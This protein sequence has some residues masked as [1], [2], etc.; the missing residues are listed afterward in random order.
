M[1]LLTKIYYTL[2]SVANHPLKRDHK[3]RAI[4]E[5]C[6][7]QVAAR[8]FTGDVLVPFPNQT[9]L[10]VSPRM[11]G[12]AHFISPGLCEFDDMSFVTHFLRPNDLFADV[13]ANIGAYTV[14]ASGVAGARTVAFEPN[15]STFRYLELNALLNDLSEKVQLLNAAVG[16]KPGRLHMT[17]NLGT[18]NHICQDTTAA[19]ASG[20]IEVEVNTLD[21]VFAAQPPALL[22]MDVEGFETEALGGAGQL[23]SHPGLL[24][25][26]V[27]RGGMAT[28]YG[29]DERALHEQIRKQGFS[30]CAYSALERRLFSVAPETIGNLI[31]VRD[32]AQVQARLKEGVALRFAG[33]TI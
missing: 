19:G 26:I 23:L 9:C 15:P 11:K 21:T 31:Y 5:F 20:S 3:W 33:A 14:L 10:V 13:G 1:N 32:P 30:P 4:R 12:G 22:K 2:Q 6:V 24:A 17:Q 18:E 25:M 8:L 7:A 29:G 16:R 27:E 28:R